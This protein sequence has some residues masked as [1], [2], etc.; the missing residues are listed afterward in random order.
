MTVEDLLDWAT[1]R[2]LE[3]VLV[4]LGSVLLTRVARW[5]AFRATLRI[6]REDRH[7]RALAQALAWLA[8]A[9][10][11]LIATLVILQKCNLPLTSLV[12]PATVAG[13]A[14]GFGAQ[15][16][17]S[18]LLSGFFLFAKSWRSSLEI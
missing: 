15:K 17:V 16:I 6:G 14:V 7:A 10:I 13:V 18:D 4:G 9:S 2:G 8:S 1:G 3:I 5:V 12:P 11:Y